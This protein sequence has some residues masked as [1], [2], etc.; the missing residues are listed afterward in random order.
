MTTN[1]ADAG[2]SDRELLVVLQRLLTLDPGDISAA[3]TDAAQQVA[4][5]LGA[6]KV[7]IFFYVPQDQALVAEGTS[8]T[9]MGHRQ[10][11]LGLDRLP[12]DGGGRTVEVFQ[13]GQSYRGDHLDQDPR[14][15]R[16]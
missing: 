11:E 8:D 6:D 15:L 4:D 2:R 16:G 5:V 3:M 10:H 1:P 9:P 12:L 7:D 13:T 14:E